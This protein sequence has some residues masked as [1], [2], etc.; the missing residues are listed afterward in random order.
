MIFLAD[1]IKL[2]STIYFYYIHTIITQLMKESELNSNKLRILLSIS[3]MLFLINVNAQVPT[4]I[5]LELRAQFN[6]QYDYKII[7]NTLNQVDNK[8]P[9]PCEMLSESSANLNLTPG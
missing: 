6:G 5:P 2:S 1:E 8:L 9:G 3:L 4:D 7:G